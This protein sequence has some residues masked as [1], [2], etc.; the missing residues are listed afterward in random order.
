[1]SMLNYFYNVKHKKH[2]YLFN[3][4]EISKNEEVMQYQNRYPVISI[5]LKEMKQSNF[6]SK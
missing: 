4:L 5:T 1:M 3:E 2:A 6:K